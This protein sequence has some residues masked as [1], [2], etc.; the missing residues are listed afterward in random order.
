MTPMPTA[1]HLA[2]LFGGRLEGGAPEA[3]GTPIGA[4]TTD[5]RR[6][7]ATTAFV[8]VRGENDDGHR[9]V[10]DAARRGAP[11]AIVDGSWTPPAET[12]APPLVIRVDE[13]AAALRRACTARLDELGC[14][15]VGITGSV[16]KTTAKEM[17]AHV[18]G[19]RAARTPGNLN[20][21]TGIPCSVLS[22][23]GEPDLYVAEMAMTAPGEIAD[24]A[25]F[26]RPVVGVLLNVG[27]SHIELLGS[28]EAIAGA[29]AELLDALPPGGLA[30]CNADDELVA[31]VAER[32]AAPVH[33]F[34][35]G[36]DVPEPA[37]RAH[38][39]EPRGLRGSDFILTTW[40]GEWT[41][42]SLGVPGRHLVS[43]ACAAAA[44]ATWAGVPLAEIGGRL[45]TWTSPEQRGRMLPGVAGSI[46]Y[47]DSYNSAPASLSAALEVLS[48]SGS[49]R[50]VAV[51]GDMLELGDEA[52]A[53]HH[54]AG[55]LIAAAATDA[56]LIGEFAE[57]M[58]EA[59]RAGGMA[60]ERIRIAGSPEQAAALVEPLCDADTT[61]LVK[62]SH[63][64]GLERLVALLSAAAVVGK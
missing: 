5:S 21:W 60:G 17:T 7:G 18:L 25:S 20:T 34:G 8:A 58:A 37:F 30:I 40:R 28:V 12:P 51:V 55:R 62:A 64:L 15:V 56:V 42:V 10:A 27:I 48:A 47:D 33:W 46:L 1:D 35:L 19:E 41:R 11:L 38:A 50:R 39:V 49:P 59:A 61:V 23:E 52:A 53:A 2:R 6:A 13:T 63:A 43:T 29:K 36:E 4:L 45:A 24:L 31:S 16:G 32:S 57:R 9:F 54:D 3:G 44:V 14:R 26:T 22:L